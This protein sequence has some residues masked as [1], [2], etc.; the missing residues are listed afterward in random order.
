MIDFTSSFGAARLQCQFLQGGWKQRNQLKTE[1]LIPI[2]RPYNPHSVS[3]IH[4]SGLQTLVDPHCCQ[5]TRT[6]MKQLAANKEMDSH[7]LFRCDSSTGSKDGCP[8]SFCL[9]KKTKSHVQFASQSVLSHRLIHFDTRCSFS[10]STNISVGDNHFCMFISFSYQN[11][12]LSFEYRSVVRYSE[13]KKM[14]IT[15]QMAQCPSL[16]EYIQLPSVVLIEQLD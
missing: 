7:Q 6:V 10:L 1:V 16:M 9:D 11:D 2:C 3:T 8:I 15:L 14:R 13:Y 12:F 4:F 5:K